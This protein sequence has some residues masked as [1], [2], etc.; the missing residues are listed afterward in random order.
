MGT[1]KSTVNRQER[2][3]KKEKKAAEQ[4]DSIIAAAVAD[5]KEKGRKA[6][7]VSA[8][9]TEQ[10]AEVVRLRGTGM[11]WWLIAYT[12]GLPGSA[13]NVKQGKSGASKARRL[14]VLASGGPLPPTA[15]SL[16]AKQPDPFGTGAKPVGQRTRRDVIR[17]APATDSMFTPDHTEE[18][19]CEMLRGKR[20]TFINSITGTEEQVRVH[21][22]SKI[23]VSLV[24]EP[25]WHPPLTLGRAVTF[26]DGDAQDDRGL[27]MKFQGMPGSTRTVR[28][29]AIVRVAS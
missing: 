22:D 29:S 5:V 21:R 14:Y 17:K 9:E 16:A 18:E 25:G 8:E 2:R 15:R 23:V 4:A 28:L 12:L 13:D 1:A 11:A 3:V 10:G 27:E 26:R 20:L 24:K 6:R 7:E 19:I